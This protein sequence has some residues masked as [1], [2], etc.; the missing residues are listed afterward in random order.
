[1]A[2]S[3][4]E[5]AERAALVLATPLGSVPGARAFGLDMA[6]VDMPAPAAAA[7]ARQSAMLAVKAC[8]P[9][10]AVAEVGAAAGEDGAL[11]PSVR[12]AAG[13]EDGLWG[14]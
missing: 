10:A 8:V 2:I 9:G 14:V 6:F 7:L 1:M 4:R 5:A 12:F 13:G 11:R 3:A